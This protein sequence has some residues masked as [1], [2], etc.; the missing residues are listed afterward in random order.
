MKK[1]FS[2]LEV[3]VVVVLFAIGIV[4]LG[5][6]RVRTME[7]ELSVRIEKQAIN[8]LEDFLEWIKSIDYETIASGDSIFGTTHITWTVY[9]DTSGLRAK[10]M[11]V[12]YSWRS[13]QGQQIIDT[14]H[15][16][17]AER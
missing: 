14:I 10:S 13:R 15:T 1:G 17:V 11:T 9:P 2:Y 16:Y 7:A 4:A 8:D 6:A 3:L 12:E 5:A